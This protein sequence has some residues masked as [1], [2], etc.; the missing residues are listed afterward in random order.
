MGDERGE[1]SEVRHRK[2]DD[3]DETSRLLG[4]AS[5]DRPED[6]EQLSGCGATAACDPRRGLHRYLILIIM[7]FLSFGMQ[8][9]SGKGIKFWFDSI[10]D[11]TG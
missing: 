11:L 1:A 5:E 10:N 7:C 3:G 9:Q 8:G 4:D 6:E 2:S